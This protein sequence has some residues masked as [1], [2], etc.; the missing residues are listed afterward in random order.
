[1]IF[2]LPFIPLTDLFMKQDVGRADQACL[3]ANAHLA[4]LKE[5]LLE[6]GI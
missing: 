6:R 5:Q 3:L 2:T 1:M 4:R